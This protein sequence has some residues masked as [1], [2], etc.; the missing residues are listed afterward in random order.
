M[1]GLKTTLGGNDKK[2]LFS[3]YWRARRNYKKYVDKLK[4]DD[5]TVL[6]ESQHGKDFN[7]QIFYMVKYMAECKDYRKYKLF[8]AVNTEYKETAEKKL[9]F[10][11]INSVILLDMNTNAYFKILASAK[12]L[13]CDVTY[14]PFFVKKKGQVILDTW[15]GTPFKT[16]GKSSKYDAYKIGN[17]EKMLVAADYILAANSF[18]SSALVKDFFLNNIACGS[19]I[20]SGYPRNEIFFDTEKG[21]NVREAITDKKH[22]YAYM[23]TFRGT[24]GAA[25]VNKADAY[26]IY[27]LC[28]IDKLLKDDEVMFV[29][30]HPLMKNLI[31]YTQLSHVRPFP[32]EYATYDVL[33]ACDVLVTDYSSVFFDFANTRKK[34]VMFPFDSEEYMNERGTY[35]KLSELPFPIAKDLKEILK[36]VRSEKEYDDNDFIKRFCPHDGIGATKRLCDFFV[37]GRDNGIV[38]E[39]IEDN[40][41][42]NVFL[43]GANLAKNGITNSL[44][45]FLQ[46]IDTSK[47]NYFVTFN[48]DVVSKDNALTLQMLPKGVGHFGTSG[49][50]N[51]TLFEHVLR[52]LFRKKLIP[53]SVYALLM[54][55]CMKENISRKYGNARIDTLIHFTG[56]EPEVILEYGA[57]E[58]RKIIF[59][60]ND[61]I[62]ETKMKKAQRKDVLKYAYRKFDKVACVTPDLV[63]SVKKLGGNKKVTVVRNLIDFD[64]IIK[65]S[66]EKLLFDPYTECTVS[67]QELDEILASGK[68]KFLN[69]GR[70][71]PEKGQ[72][73]LVKIFA[74][75]LLDDHEAV[76]IILGGYELNNVYKRLEKY[77]ITHKLTKNIVLIK[78]MSNPYPLI[79]AC[80]NF[81][82]SSFYEGFGLVIAE[83]SVL[84]KPVVSTDIV[85]PHMFMNEYG[86]TL[87]ENT[88]EGIYKGLL[89]LAEGKVNVMDIDYG[90]LRAETIG[91]FEALFKRT[92][93]KNAKKE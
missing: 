44:L 84:G 31:P 25:S 65:R 15:H 10:Y 43:Y 51:L 79:K 78:N 33:N 87:V 42:E 22:V 86:G 9:R 2:M 20:I 67:K 52:R 50:M 38:P 82:L 54:K 26:I 80:D 35:M 3:K 90:K 13:I 18:T 4:I 1:S 56:Y 24:P 53:V 29:N 57:F 39:R 40:G 55:K 47:R 12:Y 83:A 30:L 88:E 69:I 63:E 37:L 19:T 8:L 49:D 6:F 66:K 73:R 72:M 41:K 16:L 85:G 74:R 62:A 27:Y 91:E 5:K 71:A 76:L 14:L 70:F 61:M 93:M 46:N 21:K 45:T 60:H 36:E 68:K 11:G 81:V 48:T 64:K 59:S 92:G 34:I 17:A 23:P 7:G 75:Y 32:E 89:L 28:E 58:G 77:V